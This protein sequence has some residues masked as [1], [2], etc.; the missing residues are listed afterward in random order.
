MFLNEFGLCVR[1]PARR[2][3]PAPT[4]TTPITTMRVLVAL[5]F[6]LASA[7]AFTTSTRW[8][9]NARARA[10]KTNAAPSMDMAEVCD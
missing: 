2:H 4:F 1:R 9:G 7:S 5:G 3:R 8:A 6:L 10:V